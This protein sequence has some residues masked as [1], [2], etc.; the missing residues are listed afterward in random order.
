MDLCIITK[1]G[2][3]LKRNYEY[4]QTK[5]FTRQFPY[6]F[7]ANPSVVTKEK[8]LVTLD[9]VTVAEGEP[10]TAAMETDD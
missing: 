10:D 7:Q 8:K 6:D 9:D 3:E 2:T 4:L 5:E 1:E